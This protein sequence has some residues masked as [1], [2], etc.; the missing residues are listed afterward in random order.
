MK[1]NGDP[2]LCLEEL[3]LGEEDPQAGAEVLSGGG[4]VSQQAAHVHAVVDTGLPA[5]LTQQ[6]HF[7]PN[8]FFIFLPF[9]K[10]GKT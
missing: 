7:T 8:Y 6:N 5:H 4:E 2:K 10:K 3:S 1:T 9:M